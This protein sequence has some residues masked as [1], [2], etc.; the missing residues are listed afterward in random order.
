MRQILNTSISILLYRRFYLW[1]SAAE[2][3]AKHIY[4][5]S[6]IC[7][8]LKDFWE[9]IKICFRYSFLGRIT[10]KERSKISILD[11]SHLFMQSID[12]Y[13]K[14]K[15][16]IDCYLKN[17]EIGK[18]TKE[19]KEEFCAS[20]LIIVGIIII[21]AVD[22]NVVLCFFLQQSISLWGWIMHSLFFFAGA[23]AL[24]CRNDWPAVKES[25]IFFRKALQE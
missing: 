10:E 23:L 3:R 9:K 6:K 5:L 16:K 18:S 7:K 15:N 24:F 22:V 13:K 11:S 2:Q 12:F 14:W 8:L 4:R 1:Y 19:T 17:S 20:P 21:V 25:S